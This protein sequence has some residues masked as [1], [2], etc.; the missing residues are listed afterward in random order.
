[1]ILIRTLWGISQALLC[2]LPRHVC[3][4][5]NYGAD[6]NQRSIQLTRDA[7]RHFPGGFLEARKFFFSWTLFRRARRQLPVLVLYNLDERSIL[8]EAITASETGWSISNELDG[9]E[10]RH[11]VHFEPK[12]MQVL[13]TLASEPGEVVTREHLEK[14]FGPT[15]SWAKTCSSG[16]SQ[17]CVAH[18]SD[19]PRELHTIQTIPKVGRLLATVTLPAPDIAE[20]PESK[21]STQWIGS[22]ICTCADPDPDPS[23]S[24]V[25]GSAACICIARIGVHGLVPVVVILLVLAAV[26][27]F[28]LASVR[29]PC[30]LLDPARRK[31]LE[32]AAHHILDLSCSQFLARWRRRRLC[33]TV[34]GE[35]NGHIYM[36][37]LGSEAP[38]C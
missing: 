5:F 31:L 15:H 33:L 11:T 23:G 3:S 26:A 4:L 36:K 10:R 12:V 9:A 14:S 29:S 25:R 21:P 27:G 18:F 13:L 8:C 1:M 37:M 38:A 19:D 16:L 28:L 32:L 24:S 30:C 22:R 34:E 17:N 7:P 6:T 35:R 20:E 2:S